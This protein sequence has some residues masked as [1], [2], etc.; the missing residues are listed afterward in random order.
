MSAPDLKSN[1][2]IGP[3]PDPSAL[4]ADL[5]RALEWLRIHVSEPVQLDTLAA[6]SG[7]PPRTLERHF[8]T[9]FLVDAAV[10]AT[11][12]D[13]KEWTWYGSVVA[14]CARCASGNRMTTV[15]YQRD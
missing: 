6:V 9:P 12:S 8:L 2:K 7:A 15:C 11:R 5:V 13:V 14:M 10:L 3:P 4:P 1:A